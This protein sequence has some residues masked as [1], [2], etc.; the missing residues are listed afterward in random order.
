MEKIVSAITH[1]KEET[2]ERVRVHYT[3]GTTK[4]FNSLEWDMLVK[5]GKRLWDEHGKEIADLK[6]DR[7]RFDG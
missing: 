6:N 5:E 2:E 1:F 7:E 4:I 3:D